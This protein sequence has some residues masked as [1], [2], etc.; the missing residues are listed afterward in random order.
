MKFQFQCVLIALLKELPETDIMNIYRP[1]RRFLSFIIIIIFCV[2]T[3]HIS[4]FCFI[5]LKKLKLK[6]E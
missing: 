2:G 5:F 6:Y 1:W 4:K 3:V